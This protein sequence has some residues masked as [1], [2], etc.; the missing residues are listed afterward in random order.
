MH[1]VKL[2]HAIELGSAGI[3]VAE[4]SSTPKMAYFYKPWGN[5]QSF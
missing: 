4:V 2:T 1:Q 3:I 5:V